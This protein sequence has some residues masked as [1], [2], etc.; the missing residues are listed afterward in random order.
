MAFGGLM[1]KPV[2]INHIVVT[3]CKNEEKY[4]PSLIH[5]MLNQTI[6]P[7]E[8]IIVDDGSN[9]NSC[10]II[11][12]M[13]MNEKWIKCIS[14]KGIKK[15]N[16]GIEIA[17]LFAFGIEKI[18]IENWEFCSKIDSDM[19]LP[20]DYF[21]KIIQKFDQQE[22]AGILGGVCFTSMKRGRMKIEKV[23]PDHVRGG[24]KTYR[25]K[26]FEDIGGVTIA[27]G[28]DGLDEAS[29]QMIGWETKNLTNI[30]VEH[31]RETGSHRGKIVNSYIS[32]EYAYFMGYIFPYIL[33]RSTKRMF[34]KPYIIA[35]IS[36]FLGYLKNKLLRK[37]IYQNK[38]VVA[39][40]R[41]KQSRR[42]RLGKIYNQE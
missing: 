12:D 31:R 20:V 16:R 11:K 25:R 39:F 37:P 14:R 18:S 38:E 15:R 35:G 7:K 3:P 27:N 17:K 42:L 34:Q 23:E 21:E 8:W 9:D 32:G 40:I 10:N 30:K 6:R 22:K 4:I 29:A 33:G 24:L 2:Q 26:C 1:E 19:I 41:A 36:M 5:S 28:W 13:T